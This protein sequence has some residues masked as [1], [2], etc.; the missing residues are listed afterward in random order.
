MKKIFFILSILLTSI[1]SYAELPNNN[2]Y[3]KKANTAYQQKQFDSAIF[4]YDKILKTQMHNPTVH[5][6][7]GN[8]YYKSNKVSQAVL[9]YERALFFQ[10]NFDEAKDNMRLAKSR[11]PNSIKEVPDIFFVQWW[12]G[13]TS[14]NT[15]NIWAGLSIGLFLLLLVII[16]YSISTKQQ[17]KIPVQIYFIFPL[18]IFLFLFLSFTAAQRKTKCTLAVVMSQAAVLVREPNNYKGQSIVPEATTV[19]TDEIKGNW[20]SVTLPDNKT[21]WM[22]I[23][24]LK[25][26]H[27]SS[28]IK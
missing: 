6:N 13:L 10:P 21:G 15:T 5:Y 23:A 11:I 12:N 24:E 28:K 22:Q 3:W 20:V 25:L 17:N 4:Y 27:Q 2:Q 19:N 14:A 9:S 1:I 8:A 7:L 16:F 18:I 26:V